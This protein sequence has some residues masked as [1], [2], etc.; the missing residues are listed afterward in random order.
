MIVPIKT[1]QSKLQDAPEDLTNSIFQPTGY[2]ARK[3][4]KR[5]A[6][7]KA[8][9]AQFNCGKCHAIQ[10]QGGELGPALD[11]IGGHR[12]REWLTARLLDPTKQKEDFPELFD[13]KTALMPHSVKK[14]SEAKLLVDYLLTLGEPEKGFVVSHHSLEAEEKLALDNQTPASN[15]TWQ[16]KPESVASKS[17]KEIFLT[18]HCAACH[19]IDGS[20][21]WFGPDLAGIGSRMDEKRLEKILSG[22]VRSAVMKKQTRRLGDEQ[23]YDLKMFLLTLPRTSTSK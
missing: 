17:G 13:I 19:S 10:G 2:E 23:I 8:L 15:K 9:Y 1:E 6:R 7:G 20:Q 16:P 18:L 14:S 22:A 4:D 12:G 11:G 21:R 3:P 5:S